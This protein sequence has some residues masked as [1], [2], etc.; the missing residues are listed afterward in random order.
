MSDLGARIRFVLSRF[1]LIL[2]GLALALAVAEGALRLVPLPNY[3]T[4][5]RLLVSQWQPDDELL[6]RLKPDLDL[7]IYGH[8]EFSYTVRTNASGLRDEPFV[9]AFD[10]AAIGDS[11]TFGFGVEEHECWPSRLEAISGARVANL[12]W[13]GWSSY[14]YPAT[15][16]R[17]AVPLQ[18]QVWLWLFF[19][20]D[21]PESAGAEEFV[22]SG[23][24][25]F[26]AWAAEGGADFANPPFPYNLRVVQSLASLLSPGLGFP[27]GAGDRVY[28]HGTLRMHA[29]LYAWEMSDPGRQEVQRGW[30]LTEA[31]LR[32]TQDLAQEHGATL[33]VVFVP[34]R[35]HVYWPFLQAIM[36]DVDVQQLDDVEARLAGI[37]ARSGIAYLDLLPGLRA[38][39][40]DGSLLY[41]AVDGH[42][43]AAGHDVAA[44]L[45]YDYLQ[46][47]QLG[48][49]R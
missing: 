27:T 17:Y 12:G 40:A 10:V 13:A 4:F 34:S 47:G 33:V 16:R 35:E 31:A 9:G 24:T 44:H 46:A 1:L 41:F 23:E 2:L 21:L 19:V 29:D 37:C 32:E 6:L 8:P 30:Q 49:P 45:I 39:T 22:R 18:A 42:W 25:D 28:D 38:H 14:V 15:A 11:F 43:N 48:L 5:S 7:R 3:F 36:S 26:L 20:N